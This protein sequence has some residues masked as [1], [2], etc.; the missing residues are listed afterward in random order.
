MVSL[1]LEKVG[2]FVLIAILVGGLATSPVFSSSYSAFAQYGDADVEQDQMEDTERDKMKDRD[3]DYYHDKDKFVEYC[4]MSDAEKREFL[5]KHHDRIEDK[6]E[7]LD[8]FCAMSDEEREEYHKEYKDKRMD[9]EFDLDDKLER[10]CEMSD[11]EKAEVEAKYDRLTDEMKDRIAEY[12]S[13]TEDERDVYLDTHHDMM[14][15]FKK[16]HHDM[17]SDMK[18]GYDLDDKL[19]RYCEMS[20]EEKAEVEAKYDRL[21]DEMKDRIAEYCSLSED[22][23]DVYLDRHHDMM[24][25]FKG[26]HRDMVGDMQ[27]RHEDIRMQKMMER[28][29]KITDERKDEL[30]MKFREKHS[31]LSDKQ[32]DEIRFEIEVKYD[33][34]YKMKFKARHDALS[35][36]DRSDL[37]KR[38]SEMRDYKAELRERSDAM[39][40]EQRDKFRMDFYSKAKDIR[41]AWLSPHKQMMA[42]I[43]IDEIE[44][45]EGLNLVMMNSNGKPMCM[46][47]STAEKLIERGIVVPS[48]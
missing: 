31:D 41:H 43:S 25:D 42:G 20:D 10:Y 29:F 17:L 21:T 22:E 27:E 13:L 30:K 15:D 8:R 38:H 12:C 11:E 45:R 18:D 48:S 2:L 16:R 9:K 1:N 33:K 7:K 35:D 14:M 47:S 4:E 34:H 36:Q 39:T 5:A 46:K 6:A 24:M 40:D 44:C 19:E 3:D 26:K 32:R 23:R 28:D 37:L